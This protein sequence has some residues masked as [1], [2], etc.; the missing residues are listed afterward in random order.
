MVR[1]ESILLCGILANLKDTM[2]LIYEMLLEPGENPCET[3]LTGGVALKSAVRDL[4]PYLER[5]QK[6]IALAREAIA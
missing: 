3:C 4:E 1:D 6:E 5:K 2:Q